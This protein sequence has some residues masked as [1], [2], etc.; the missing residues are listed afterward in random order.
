MEDTAKISIFYA[1]VAEM[2]GNEVPN[3]PSRPDLQQ[4]R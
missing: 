3:R 4:K 1:L 2:V